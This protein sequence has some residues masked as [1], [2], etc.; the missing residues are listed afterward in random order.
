M[1]FTT[2]RWADRSLRK[3]AVALLALGIAAD[4]ASRESILQ[5]IGPH[6]LPRYQRKLHGYL[7]SV[8]WSEA[9]REW[10]K[11]IPNRAVSLHE[12]YDWTELIIGSTHVVLEREERSP[13]SSRKAAL[14]HQLSDANLPY[15]PHVQPTVITFLM[16]YSEVTGRPSG[17][18][19]KA[20]MGKTTLWSPIRVSRAEAVRLLTSWRRRDVDFLAE[21]DTWAARHATLPPAP[22]APTRVRALPAAAEPV[23]P[24]IRPGRR[25]ASSDQAV[26][27]E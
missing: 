20:Q 10:Q 27:G 16:T 6:R 23:K 21:M 26:N 14:R 4:E 9:T 2:R 22:S 25:S 12:P 17:L 13:R 8:L 1:E 18:L 5:G 24:M 7:T 15:L 11:P 19:V 3:H